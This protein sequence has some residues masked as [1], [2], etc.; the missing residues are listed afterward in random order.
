MKNHKKI[1]ISLFAAISTVATGGPRAYHFGL[2]KIMFL[3][4]HATTRQQTMME[5]GIITFKHNSALTFSHV[6][7]KSLATNCCT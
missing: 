2:L 7:A 1:E 6:F 5:K 3:E 4:P